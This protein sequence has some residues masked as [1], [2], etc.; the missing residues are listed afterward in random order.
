MTDTSGPAILGLPSCERLEV[1]KMK[2]AVKVIQ[3]TSCLPGSSPAPPTPK[4]TAPIKFTEDLI[5][6][7]PE[8]FQGI[9]QFPSE[10][11]IRL[12]DNAEPVIHAPQNVQF[13][14]V[15]KL[16]KNWTQWQNVMSS[17]L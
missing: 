17:P 12:C 4:K 8:R 6:K 13:P 3:D 16:R 14:Y 5:R 10:Y 2:C 7:F 11:T 15:L 9:A 1:V